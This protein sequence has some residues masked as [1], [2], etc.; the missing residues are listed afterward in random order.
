DIK[1]ETDPNRVRWRVLR[2]GLQEYRKLSKKDPQGSREGTL[3][4]DS[5]G[6]ILMASARGT[7]P[8]PGKTGTS[9]THYMENNGLAYEW[10]VGEF[11][12]YD[13]MRAYALAKA[14]F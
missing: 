10:A 6:A 4:Y 7:T 3:C 8:Q 12:E 9:T 14:A 13:A 11:P 5:V 2:Y 1:L